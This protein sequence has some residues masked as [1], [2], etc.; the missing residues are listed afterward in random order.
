MR[1]KKLGLSIA[2]LSFLSLAPEA[3]CQTRRDWIFTQLSSTSIPVSAPGLGFQL[4]VSTLSYDSRFSTQGCFFWDSKV[5]ELGVRTSGRVLGP[6]GVGRT[7]LDNTLHEW[8]ETYSVELARRFLS[9]EGRFGRIGIQVDEFSPNQERFVHL[10]MDTGILES[11]TE[12][13]NLKLSFHLFHPLKRGSDSRITSSIDVGH[14]F[15]RWTRESLKAGLLFG[16]TYHLSQE[17]TG[18]VVSGLPDKS[19]RSEHMIFSANPWI[20]YSTPAFIAKVAIPLRLFMDKE[21]Q[22]KTVL[23]TSYPIEVSSPDIFASVVFLL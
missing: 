16:W 22:S 3:F 7:A 17:Q 6:L 15:I 18:D 14:A 5:V 9:P 12:P 11:E 2:S 21:W 23:V 13:G 20:E 4:G 19:F 1:L 8:T 10:A